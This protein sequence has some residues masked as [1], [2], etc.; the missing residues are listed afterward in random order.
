VLFPE[1]REFFLEGAGVFEVPGIDSG[2]RPYHS[3]R[4]GLD[5]GRTIPILVGA[6]LSGRIGSRYRLGLMNMQT[7]SVDGRPGENFSVL[8][9]KRDM[10]RRS[11][12]G[13]FATNW[14]NREG[15]R[16]LMMGTDQNFV[17]LRHLTVNGLF[18]R[19]FSSEVNDD[20]VLWGAAS[21]WSSS[22]ITAGFDYVS[23]GDDFRADVGFLQR[24]GVRK[25][26][27]HFLLSP[28]PSGGPIRQYSFGVDIDHFRRLQGDRLET[29]SVEFS[30]PEIMFTD[31]SLLRFSPARLTEVLDEPLR[32]AGGLLVPPGTYEWWSMPVYYELN[33]AWR[34]TGNLQ[35]RHDRDYFGRGGRRQVWTVRP[36]IRFNANFS[37][38]ISY[39]VNRVQ[40][41]GGNPVSIH[42]LNSRFNVAFS[43]RLTTSTLAQYSTTRNLLGFNFRLR[44]N[45]RSGDDLY[46]VVNGF[47]AG[48]EAVREIDRS[49]TLKFTRSFDF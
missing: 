16:S 3:R 35:Y 34:L 12:V 29:Q 47:R 36:T 6:K 21:E 24:T 9:V 39:S 46:V 13:L 5:E 38:E 18:A 27:P 8:R 14:H 32:L 30:S 10:L 44:Y 41:P 48:V 4:I 43:R 17:F 1:K 37:S 31:A 22:L 7:R 15:D 26:R 49:I 42:V 20:G 23:V 28:R 33:P 25:Y 45:Y 2:V 40:L 11:S 19:S